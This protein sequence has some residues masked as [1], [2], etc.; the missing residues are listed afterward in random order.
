VRIIKIIKKEKQLLLKKNQNE[1]G[2]T[3]A[4][5]VYQKE[6]NTEIIL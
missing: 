2:I 3:K 1:R 5:D 4:I 6:H